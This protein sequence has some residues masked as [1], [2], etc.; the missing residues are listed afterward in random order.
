MLGNQASAC[1]RG[2]AAVPHLRPRHRAAQHPWAAAPAHHLFMRLVA[3]GWHDTDHRQVRTSPAKLHRVSSREPRPDRVSLDQ[4]E[5]CVAQRQKQ[6]ARQFVRTYG[7]PL[8]CPGL[9]RPGC[10]FGGAVSHCGSGCPPTSPRGYD[11]GSNGCCPTEDVVVGSLV[12]CAA[13]PSRTAPMDRCTLL[14]C[15]LPSKGVFATVSSE[16]CATL[17]FVNQNG[18]TVVCIDQRSDRQ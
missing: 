4:N 15:S 16:G 1:S 18:C 9:I 10:V 17:H 6:A 11:R 8:I 3:Q 2:H 14:R 13:R 7:R 5:S 12:G